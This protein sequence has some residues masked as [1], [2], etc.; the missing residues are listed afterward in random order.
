MKATIKNPTLKAL[1]ERT[2]EGREIIK[3]IGLSGYREIL[4]A[5]FFSKVGNVFSKIGKV[6]SPI[7]GRIAKVG[8]GLIGIPPGA[9]D[10]LAKADPTAHK[11]LLQSV[12]NSSAGKQA[13]SIVNAAESKAKG[14]IGKIKP[15]Y[16]YAGAGTLAAVI[17][18]IALKKKK[19][20]G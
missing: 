7:T 5:S 13:A 19:K 3:D 20:R 4:G 12:L 6:T 1:L 11:S 17:V 10:A 14:A 8:A 15:V 18:I 9:I 2:S 16:L